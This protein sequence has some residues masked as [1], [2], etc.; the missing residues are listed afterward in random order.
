MTKFIFVMVVWL[1]PLFFIA[2]CIRCTNLS[3]VVHH[4]CS[5]VAV[6]VVVVVVSVNNER[7]VSFADCGHLCAV[8][9]AAVIPKHS[10]T[11][12]GELV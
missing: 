11:Q 10:V 2:A 12:T 8:Q 1:P 4:W 7:V 6:V 9:P 3:T 5:V